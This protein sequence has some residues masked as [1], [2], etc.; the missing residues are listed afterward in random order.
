MDKQP[1]HP[2]RSR[3]TRFSLRTLFVLVTALCCWLGYQL[4]LIR[5]R[6]ALLAEMLGQT[7]I[8][9]RAGVVTAANESVNHITPTIAP[10]S[11]RLFREPAIG[12][13]AVTP[14]QETE[15]KWHSRAKRLFPEAVCIIHGGD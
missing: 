4:N 7:D 14:H 8:D 15:W 12:L 2:T 9:A 5:E 1:A 6:H 11:L 13:I 3:W 10:W